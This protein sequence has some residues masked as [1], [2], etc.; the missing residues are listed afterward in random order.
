MLVGQVSNAYFPVVLP[1]TRPLSRRDSAA[2]QR[3]LHL[4]RRDRLYLSHFGRSIMAVSREL[5]WREGPASRSKKGLAATVRYF[6]NGFE[7]QQA[8]RFAQTMQYWL[9]RDP[10]HLQTY[11]T[12][13]ADM[14]ALQFSQGPWLRSYLLTETPLQKKLADTAGRV[15]EASGHDSEQGRRM[16][17]QFL[18]EYQRVLRRAGAEQRPEIIRSFLASFDGAGDKKGR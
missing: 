13:A 8:R 3:R 7:P 5:S 10:D 18:S 15:L 14:A 12:A 4:A 9:R 11:F 16:V 2:G 6:G 1:P 17:E